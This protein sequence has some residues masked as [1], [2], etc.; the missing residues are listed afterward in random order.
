MKTLPFLKLVFLLFGVL[1]QGYAQES[2]NS[3]EKIKLKKNQFEL[4]NVIGSIVKF[5]GSKVLKIERDLN[6]IP[7]DE[8]RI[9]ETVDE[10]HYARLVGLEDFE[11]GES[12]VNYKIPSPMR[13]SLDL[14]GCIFEFI[15]RTRP[16]M[17]FI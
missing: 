16:L 1:N 15:Q 13:G 5:E 8:S 12:I 6:A 11:K 14:S 2:N 17:E 4:H 10:P 9:E 3:W 7:F